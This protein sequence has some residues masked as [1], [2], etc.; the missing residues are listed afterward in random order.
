MQ[1]TAAAAGGSECDGEAT[2]DWADE[3]DWADEEEP[4]DGEECDG[5]VATGGEGVP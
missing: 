1:V 5:E 3:A 4:V 2:M